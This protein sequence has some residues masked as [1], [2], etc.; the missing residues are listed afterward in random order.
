MSELSR[1]SGKAD[2]NIEDGVDYKLTAIYKVNGVV[3]DITGYSASF[4]LRENAGSSNILLSLTES[5][6]IAITGAL[7]K[8]FVQI[9]DTQSIYGSRK[10]V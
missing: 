2:I 4:K 7:G 8:V 6:G 10:M 5:S 1:Q 3:V 9:A